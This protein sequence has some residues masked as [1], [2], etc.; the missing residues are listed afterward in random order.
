MSCAT[1]PCAIDCGDS[2]VAPKIRDLLRWT[3][4]IGRRR[5]E[6]RDT[7]LARYHAKADRRLDALLGS[8][9]AHPAGRALQAQI[10]AWRGK[11]FVFLT[12]RRVPATN[13]I[14]ER[15]IRPSVVFRKV[16]NGF[17]SEWGAGVH[18][19]YRSLTSTARLHGQT[20]MDAVH[21]LVSG[22]HLNGMDAILPTR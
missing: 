17:R 22:Q 19:G 3:I 18:A 12:D 9:A 14:S 13:T 11:V 1:C 5:G 2:V 15:E 8:P 10:K 7:T 20:T 16:T 6:L 21:A 4:R